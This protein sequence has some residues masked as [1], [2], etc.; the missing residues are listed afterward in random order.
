LIAFSSSYKEVEMNGAVLVLTNTEDG[1]H[2]NVVISKL[3]RAGEGV[4]RLDVDKLASGEIR[5]LFS[6]NS[7]G[8]RFTLLSGNSLLDSKDIKSVWYRRPNHFNLKIKDPVQ[9]SYTERELSTFLDGLWSIVP[10]RAFWL[11]YPRSLEHARKKIYQLELAQELG[12]LIPRTII[13]NDPEK[14]KEFYSSCH[15]KM[16]FKAIY[17]EF[18]NYGDKTFNIPTTLVTE[19]HLAQIDLIKNLPALFQEFISKDYE[20]RITVVGEKF[21]C[22]KIDSQKNPLTIVDWRNPIYINHL[23]YSEIKTPDWLK[24]ICAEMLRI[25]DL[26]FGAFDFVVDKKGRVFFLEVNPNG[27]WY[28]LESL[29][30]ALISDA[31]VDT[32]RRGR[33]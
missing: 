23:S 28:W 29:T 4:F 33:G 14:V 6:A 21:F 10:Q 16:V 13:T 26:S 17:H 9:R 15:G 24:R 12:L 3:E 20:M 31:I 1:E 7:T 11:S 19:R 30:G 5:V 27:Q 18:L 8:A 25:L 22:I 2:T 32:L